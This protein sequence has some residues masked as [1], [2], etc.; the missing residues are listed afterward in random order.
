[1]ICEK[2]LAYL[3]EKKINH[4]DIFVALQ[5]DDKVGERKLYGEIDLTAEEYYIIC[6]ILKVDLNFFAS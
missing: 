3:D 4:H 2:I 5:I 1:M 6:R